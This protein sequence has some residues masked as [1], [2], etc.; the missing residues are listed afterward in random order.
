MRELSE[1]ENNPPEG[2]RV[3]TSDEDMLDV[4]GIIEGPGTSISINLSNRSLISSAE[5]TPYAGGY[6]RVKF[7]FTEEFPSAPPKCVSNAFV[8]YLLLTLG[9]RLVCNKD[10]PSQCWRQ[11]RDLRQHSEKRLEIHIWNWPHSCHCQVPPHLS[12]PRVCFGRGGR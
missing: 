9:S 12:E 11:W 4:T 5:G 6:F 7:K 8:L 1:L 10:L 2:I 3:Q